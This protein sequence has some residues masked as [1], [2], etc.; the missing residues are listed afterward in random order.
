V[1]KIVELTGLTNEQFFTRHAAPGCV[2][3][4]G[5]TAL[6][7]R[8]ICRAQRHVDEDE[9]W[10]CWSHAFLIQGPRLDGHTWVVE[11]D[12][13]VQRK[14]IRLGVQENR[15]TKYFNEQLYS[16]VAILD[17]GLTPAQVTA[18]LSEGLNLVA[19]RTQYSI[20][21]LIGALFAMKH[22]RLRGK[23]NFLSRDKSLFCSA[24]VHH[25]FRSAEINLV[26]GLEV[27]HTAPEDIF[28]STLPHTTYLL[29]RAVATSRFKQIREKLDARLGERSKQHRYG[30]KTV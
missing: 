9:N 15:I 4:A 26:P 17:F 27:K 30:Q 25:L 13:D 3:L 23:S 10:S 5:G 7:D 20:R 2:A 21:E 6:I 24:L 11:S 8:V 19:D 12:L 16:T 1:N 29:K 28:R 22:Q 14:H 18:V